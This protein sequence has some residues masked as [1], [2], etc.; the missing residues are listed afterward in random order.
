M[1]SFSEYVSLREM[2]RDIGESSFSAINNKEGYSELKYE[3]TKLLP[4][5]K[6]ISDDIIAHIDKQPDGNVKIYTN[7]HKN[8]KTIHLTHINFE[9]KSKLF[10]DGLIRQDLVDRTN[11]NEYIPKNYATN[12][13]YDYWKSQNIPLRTSD[14]QYHAGH[15]MWEKLVDMALNDDKFVYRKDRNSDYL[16][17]IDHGNKKEELENTFGRG[18]DFQNDHI[19]LS[20]SKLD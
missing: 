19:I 4:V 15:H 6:K 1:L 8:K 5:Y 17:K 11:K 20:H 13:I 18:S 16:I 7:D 2:A 9:P 12:T 10:P 14:T 3:Q